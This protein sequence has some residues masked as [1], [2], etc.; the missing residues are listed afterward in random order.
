M[1]LSWDLFYGMILS[2]KKKNKANFTC[3]PNIWTGAFNGQVII[4][5]FSDNYFPSVRSQMH[6]YIS[7]VTIFERSLS[8][9]F[10]QDTS[11]HIKMVV[12]GGQIQFYAHRN[13]SCKHQ[14]IQYAEKYLMTPS[15]KSY[16]S[17]MKMDTEYFGVL[18]VC[19]LYSI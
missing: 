5:K 6:H 4:F 3:T 8:F 12:P 13:L 19:S 15:L 9:L 7:M 14:A 2:F 16:W 10:M 1:T 17:L 18:S 11:L